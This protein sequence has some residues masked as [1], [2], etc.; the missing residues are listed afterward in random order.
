MEEAGSFFV[1][2][3]GGRTRTRVTVGQAGTVNRPPTHPTARL[4]LSAGDH[5]QP[6]SLKPH[7]WHFMHP[8]ANSSCDPQSGQA[9][10]S[11]SWSP[12]KIICSPRLPVVLWLTTG[13]SSS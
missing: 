2:G 6:H 10:E 5:D 8:S 12:V 9:P 11:V 1:G 7:T 3:S 4:Q 13:A